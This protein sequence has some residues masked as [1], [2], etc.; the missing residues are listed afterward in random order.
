MG[1]IGVSFD[2][3]SL[4]AS[5]ILFFPFLYGSF[6]NLL[7]VKLGEIRFPYLWRRR[8]GNVNN[9]GNVFGYIQ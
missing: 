2:N 3:A 4:V 7:G 5:K 6:I 1:N 9:E 8:L